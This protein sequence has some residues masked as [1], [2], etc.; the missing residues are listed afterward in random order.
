MINGRKPEGCIPRGRLGAELVRALRGAGAADAPGGKGPTGCPED[1]FQ[2]LSR[3]LRAHLEVC[4]MCR[5]EYEELA[6]FLEHYAHTLEN[7]EMDER[8]DVLGN[9]ADTSSEDNT[10]G[11]KRKSG[12]IELPYQP[13]SDPFEEEPSLAAATGPEE[14]E[15]LRFCSEDG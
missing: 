2:D 6:L 5:E 3:E 13:Y 4:E 8:F 1:P 10:V 14:A 15:R 7:T 9:L 11:G 12:W